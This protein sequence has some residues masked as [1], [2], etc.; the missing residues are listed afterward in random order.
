VADKHRTG[1]S[2]NLRGIHYQLLR[3]LFQANRIL[4]LKLENSDEPRWSKLV[5][6]PRDGGDLQIEA[7]DVIDVEQMKVR[8]Q[9]PWPLYEVIHEVLPD[10]YQAFASRSP[11]RPVREARFVTDAGRGQWREV[12]DFFRSLEPCEPGLELPAAR[13]DDSVLLRVNASKLRAAMTEKGLGF[14]KRGL[15][16]YIARIITKSEVDP[17]PQEQCWVWELLRAFRFQQAGHDRLR[18][19]VL[20]HIRGRVSGNA[21][22]VLHG[23]LGELLERGKEN[24]A[25]VVR[26]LLV[27]HGL[28]DIDLNDREVLVARGRE[29]LGRAF[30]HRRYSPDLDVRSARWAVLPKQGLARVKPLVFSGESGKG[31]SWAL[32]ARALSLAEQGRLVLLI[33]AA[34]DR[35]ATSERAAAAFCREIWGQDGHVSLERLHERLKTADP[36][37]AGDW[38]DLLVDGVQSIELAE[39]LASYDWSAYG[40]RLSFSLTTS[41]TTLPESLRG[42]CQQKEVTDFSTRELHDYF[43]RRLGDGALQVPYSERSILHQPL[44]ARIFCDLI[45]DETA[46]IPPASEFQLMASYWATFAGMR[47]LAAASIAELAAQPPSGRDY[48]WTMGTLRQSGIEESAVLSLTDRGLLRRSTDGRTAALWHDRLLSWAV[49]EGWVAMIRDGQ[50]T[51]QGLVERLR[52]LRDSNTPEARWGRRWMGDAQ[53]DVLWILLEPGWGLGQL[54]GEVLS[55]LNLRPEALVFLGDRVVPV[56]IQRVREKPKR[57]FHEIEALKTI[58][59]PEVSTRTLDLLRT[60]EVDV[61]LA[62]ARILVQQ[63]TPDAL[64]AL[65][66]LRCELERQESQDL[67]AIHLIVNKA[68]ASCVRQ[69]DGWLRRAIRR[70]DP[71]SE[72]VHDL[73]YLLPQME[74]GRELWFELKETIF[75]KVSGKHERSIVVCLEN[76]LDDGNIEWLKDRVQDDSPLG[77]AARRALFLLVPGRRPDPIEGE[78]TLLGFARGW[79]LLPHVNADPEIA[80]TFI[81]QTVER[82]EDPWD[83]AWTLLS[84]FES[85]I[86]PETLDRLLDALAERLAREISEPTEDNKDPLW[87]PFLFLAKVRSLRLIERFEAHQGGDLELHLGQWLCKQGANNERYHRHREERAVRI[88]ERIGGEALT[89]VANCWLSDGRTFWAL[90]EAINLAVLRP[91]ERTAELLYEVA[92]REEVEGSDHPFAQLAAIGALLIIG[93]RDLAVRGAMKWALKLSWEDIDLFREYRPTAADLE[94][95][96]KALEK[97]EEFDPNIVLS[98]GL[99]GRAQDA[100]FI[101]GILEKAPPGSELALACL[102]ALYVIGDKSDEAERSFL[103][104]LA[105]PKTEY[106]STLGLL[107]IRTPEALA[108]LKTRINGLNKNQLSASDN[109]VLI[110]V[111]LLDIEETQQEV[112]EVLWKEMDHHRILFIVQGEFSA[113]AKIGR[114]DIDEW[115]YGLALGEEYRFDFDAQVGAIRVLVSR[116]KDRAFDAALRLEEFGASR[117]EE[118]PWLLLDIDQ[119]RALPLLRDQLEREDEVIVLAAIGESLCAVGLKESIIEWLKDASPRVRESA[120]IAAE[121]FPWSDDLAL[122]LRTLLYNPDWYV[123]NAANQALDRLWHTREIDRLVDALLAAP[124]T[125]QGW[126]L[127][128]IIVEAAHPGLWRRQPWVGKLRELPLAMLQ[129][130]DEQ[131]EKRRKEV[132]DELKKRKRRDT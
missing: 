81:A 23:L 77:A 102:L 71:G 29:L 78:G 109:A 65:W 62:G 123:R 1:G 41:G 73:V 44:L 70:A 98:I 66:A 4:N 132:R 90:R 80:E 26:A 119:K 10:L 99:G 61:R 95:A 72:P 6:E 37:H 46:P 34:V 74:H 122:A 52:E 39:Q 103:V 16:L 129:R 14:T 120:C 118:V 64:D 20:L 53:L 63:P 18:E 5:I 86:S 101:L 111:N 116:D 113:F 27:H 112:A 67:N 127:L 48:P 13:L 75:S 43:R 110:A 36:A 35:T 83:V 47:P 32:Y 79:W 12:E 33:D 56:L 69:A 51:A 89:Q 105:S 125:T 104:H 94:P 17:G 76:F 9:G 42:L 124:N 87:A 131:L 3:S 50:M 126:C 84:G 108:E 58:Q 117:R 92:M 93:R 19:D 85:R 11:Y 31:K 28:A 22:L 121:V 97:Q 55:Q 40:I 91:D 130:V 49:A 15:F 45:G 106:V 82:A 107:K 96:R 114:S 60:E 59:S 30:G 24:A 25:I 7:P 100:P 88:L 68:L 2:E 38:L 128:D 21:E 8:S 57:S 115:L 54:V